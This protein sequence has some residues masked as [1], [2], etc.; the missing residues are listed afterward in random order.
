MARQHNI[1]Q[2]KTIQ[3]K[4]TQGNEPTQ[5]KTR[6]SKTRQ[7]NTIQNKTKQ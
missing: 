6:H 1:I 7:Y 5:Y 2:Y 4:P 3:D